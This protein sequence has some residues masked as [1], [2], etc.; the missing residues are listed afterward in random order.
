MIKTAIAAPTEDVTYCIIRRPDGTRFMAQLLA[1]GEN[2]LT[3]RLIHKSS[4]VSECKSW[5]PFTSVEQIDY[6]PVDVLDIQR[7]AAY[8]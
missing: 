3:C 4:G 6:P 8:L 5:I 7:L 1:W 2:G